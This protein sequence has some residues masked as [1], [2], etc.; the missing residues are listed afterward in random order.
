MGESESDTAKMVTLGSRAAGP[1][2]TQK[3]NGS[4]AQTISLRVQHSLIFW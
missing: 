3:G 1:T 2:V 4:E